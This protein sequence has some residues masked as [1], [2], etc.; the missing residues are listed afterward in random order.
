M[1]QAEFRHVRSRWQN[2]S[3]EKCLSP[4]TIPN[5]IR[6]HRSPWLFGSGIY[7]YP[8]EQNVN[9]LQRSY[10]IIT[11]QWRDVSGGGYSVTHDATC[12]LFIYTL[13][14][15][16]YNATMLSK[17]RVKNS[18]VPLIILLE[19]VL[20]NARYTQLYIISWRCTLPSFLLEI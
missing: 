9:I 7:Y 17:T 4:G 20:V 14:L 11:Y 6:L 3:T 10:I 2:I 13:F 5:V 12:Y 16:S 8:K 1:T 18:T 19:H 15:P